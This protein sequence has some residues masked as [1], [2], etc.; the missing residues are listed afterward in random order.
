MKKGINWLY[1]IIELFVV[2]LGISA[3]F[4]LQNYK[5]NSAKKEL[6]I[7]YLKGFSEDLVVNLKGLNEEIE[8]DSLWLEHN[9]YAINYFIGDSLASDSANSLVKEMVLFSRFAPQT[10]TYEDIVNT[11]NL[12]LITDY[13]LKQEIII[14]H[15]ELED[16]EILEEYYQNFIQ[17]TFM[18]FIM[19]KYDLFKNQFIS[20]KLHQSVEFRN[21]YVGH[22]SMKQQRMAGYKKLKKLTEEL[23]VKLKTE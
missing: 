17:Q 12:N 1:L 14:Y 4:V 19:N 13:Q 16:F 18:P 20:G 7:N 3:G 2:F 6:E 15:K 8:T 5:D 21:I 9:K 23:M 11:G 22:Y 10:Y